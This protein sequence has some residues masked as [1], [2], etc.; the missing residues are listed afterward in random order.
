MACLD[1]RSALARLTPLFEAEQVEDH[2]LVTDETMSLALDVEDASFVWE[3]SAEEREKRLQGA[4]KGKKGS[5]KINEKA[6]AN[7]EKTDTVQSKPFSLHHITLRI[8][9]GQVI[10]I[11]GPVG[12]GK[13]RL[14]HL[15]N[16]T[17][18]NPP[19]NSPPYY[20]VWL[21]KCDRLRAVSNSVVQSHI[22]RR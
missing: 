12:S 10:A 4:G 2:K 16:I 21:V 14:Q 9:R 6:I 18:D 17:T 3:E 13:V 20:K 7:P 11:V 22:V 1:A 8:P 15:C 5:K 19:E